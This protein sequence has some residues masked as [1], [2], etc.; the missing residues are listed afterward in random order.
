MCYTAGAMVVVSYNCVLIFQSLYK[1][2][3]NNLT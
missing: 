2:I 1:I 3:L